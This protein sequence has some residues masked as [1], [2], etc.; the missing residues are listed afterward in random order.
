MA[1]KPN[2]HDR[3]QSIPG[4]IRLLANALAGWI[5]TRQAPFDRPGVN[6]RAAGTAMILKP[7]VP[8]PSLRPR[9]V[10][11]RCR[12]RLAGCCGWRSPENERDQGSLTRSRSACRR[13]TTLPPLACLLVL[14]TFCVGPANTD[15][16]LTQPT[17][18]PTNDRRRM[19]ATRG[20]RGAASSSKV[21][22]C[23]LLAQC[24]RVST[25]QPR[26]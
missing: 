13:P 4:L 21:R 26:A 12:R 6:H 20:S 24:P 15:S 3:L 23:R 11:S 19:V 16:S 14:L 5:G 22:A 9:E 1:A 7:R 18:K 25:D 17:N 10:S 8:G 2:R